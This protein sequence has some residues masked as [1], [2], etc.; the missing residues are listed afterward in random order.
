MYLA[1][2]NANQFGGAGG[3]GKYFAVGAESGQLSADLSL[4][5]GSPQ[6]YIGF[7]LSAL[8][9]NNS[10]ELYLGSTLVKSYDA[11]AVSGFVGSNSA[12]KGNPNAN[13]LG[14]DATQPFAYLNFVGTAGTTFDTVKFKNPTTNTGLEIDN[15][16]IRE[17][18]LDEIPGTPVGAPLPMA[19]WGGL[20]LLGGFAAM[21]RRSRR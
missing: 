8:D 21:G 19:A 9:A 12:Y 17:T 2:V 3:T 4:D 18:P 6:A 13:F 7:W 11:A 10:I 5:A 16:S 1:V 15:I 14:Q 20:T